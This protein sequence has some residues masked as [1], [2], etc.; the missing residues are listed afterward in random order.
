MLVVGCYQAPDYGGTQFKCDA[1]HPCPAGQPCVAGVCNGSGGGSAAVDAAT[2][3]VGVQCGATACAAT[4]KCCFDFIGAPSCIAVG[5]TC[6]GIAATCDGLEDCSGGNCCETGGTQ[7]ACAPTCPTQ[8][9]CLDNADCINA[10]GSQ[11]CMGA[12]GIS[13]PWGRCFAACP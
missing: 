1:D 2:N 4:Q 3:G 6:A 12:G 11:C 5:A 13:E 9:I 10:S 7:I 8:T